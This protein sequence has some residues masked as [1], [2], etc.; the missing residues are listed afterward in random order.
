MAADESKTDAGER[1]EACRVSLIFG[2]LTLCTV[3]P[4]AAIIVVL[5]AI[6]TGQGADVVLLGLLPAVAIAAACGAAVAR[7]TWSQLQPAAPPSRA[8]LAVPE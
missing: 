4:V 7:R 3:L 5:L 6:T 2:V 1:I 8:L